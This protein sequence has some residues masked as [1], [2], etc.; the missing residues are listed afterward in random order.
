MALAAALA[1]NPEP[2]T[3]QNQIMLHRAIAN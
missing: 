3:P 1:T 2:S